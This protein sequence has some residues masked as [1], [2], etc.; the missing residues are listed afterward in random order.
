MKNPLPACGQHDA[1]DRRIGCVRGC[2]SRGD[3]C[4]LLDPSPANPCTSLRPSQGVSYQGNARRPIPNCC[5]GPHP[6]RE[7]RR[8]DVL[9]VG[10]KSSVQSHASV[11]VS[12]VPPAPK[13][14]SGLR[15]PADRL[16][17]ATGWICSRPQFNPKVA[18]TSAWTEI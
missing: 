3:R 4:V 18:P 2:S 7:N 13:R 1:C 5:N 10:V 6:D 14:A 17:G 9:A 15:I 8:T 11:K 16:T 12:S